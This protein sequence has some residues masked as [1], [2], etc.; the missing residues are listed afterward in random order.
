MNRPKALLFDLGDTLVGSLKLDALAGH[1][2]HLEIA[3]NRGELTPQDVSNAARALD[4]ELAPLRESS[5]LEN[6][7]QQFYR[8]LHTRLCLNLPVP[9][10]QVELE[11]WQA[12]V[13]Y[14]P[15]PGIAEALPLLKALGLRLGVV[16]NCPYASHV[17]RWELER[18]N[19]L[20]PFEFVLSSSDV[21][22]KKP[23]ALLFTT[24]VTMLQCDPAE[25]WFIGDTL[26][27]DIAGAQ[28]AGL[29]AV[30]YN[31]RRQERQSEIVP[32]AE[33]ADWSEFVALAQKLSR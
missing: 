1:A 5:L 21:G 17:L 9:Y 28:K 26:H 11:F 20:R 32:D 22:I 23:H 31:R 16:S 18:H 33:I 10:E 15:E 25:V 7:A 3:E 13:R 30:W 14:F 4:E 8:L 6:P 2:R 27:A 24:A 12:A 19:L 29:Q